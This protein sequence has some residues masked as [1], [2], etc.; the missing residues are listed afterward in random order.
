MSEEDAVCDVVCGE[1]RGKADH[2][3][4][5]MFAE[6]RNQLK[7]RK[8]DGCGLDAHTDDETSDSESAIGEGC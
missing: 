7:D 8:C 2:F 3:N 4:R 1:S 6:K 5:V